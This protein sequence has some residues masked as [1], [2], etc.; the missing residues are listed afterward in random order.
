MSSTFINNN[1]GYAVGNNGTIIKTTNEGNL[2]IKITNILT[3]T[4]NPL[5]SVYFINENIGVASGSPGIFIKTTNSGINWSQFSTGTNQALLSTYFINENIGYTAGTHSVILK[6]VNGGLNWQKITNNSISD[7]T[8]Q[9]NTI[10]FVNEVT[11]YVGGNNSQIYMTT[12]GGMNWSK[13]F[14]PNLI[15]ITSIYF[16]N[17]NTGF[18][19]G[20]LPSSGII[21]KTT[22]GGTNWYVT[23]IDG[24][25]LWSIKFINNQIGYATGWGG[26]LKSTDSGENWTLIETTERRSITPIDAQTIYTFGS[27]GSISKTI[28]GGSNWLPQFSGGPNEL[29]S[30]FMV[31]EITGYA[32]SFKTTNG[33]INWIYKGPYAITDFKSIYFVN[34]DSG[35]AI[36]YN[37]FYKTI[38]GGNNWTDTSLGID[39]YSMHFLNY[40]TGYIA[41]YEKILKTTDAGVSWAQKSNIGGSSFFIVNEFTAYSGTNINLILKTTNG[42]NNWITQFIPLSEYEKIENIFF[43]N[44]NTGFACGGDYGVIFK[45]TNGGINWNINHIANN[46]LTSIYFTDIDTGYA[47]G[48]VL[49]KTTNSGNS[50]NILNTGIEV[51]ILSIKFVNRNIGYLCGGGGIILKT[52]TGGGEPIGLINIS[53]NV[54]ADFKLFQ[55]YPNPFNP[56]TKIKYDIPKDARVTLKVYDVLGKEIYSSNEFKKAGRYEFEFDGSNYASGLYFYRIETDKY[57]DTKKMV[58]VK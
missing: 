28:N 36:Q 57:K 17:N 32:G 11:G 14:P 34:S 42:G 53:S 30:I 21:Q 51:G 16:N 27:G 48:S 33:G 35:Y 41:G 43:I 44:E 26:T 9:F 19:A 31:D 50:W 49:L 20:G 22:N 46:Y 6:T 7:S 39:L 10:F 56:A 15:A 4:N 3:G 8:I 45:T 2:W 40:H 38:N 13:Q 23:A 37:K 29:S 58:L 5:L 25:Y 1:T 24:G 55:N 12:N 54:P 18:I 52:T 47:G